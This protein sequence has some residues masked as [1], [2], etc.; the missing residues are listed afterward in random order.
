MLFVWLSLDK[1]C[2]H[3]QPTNKKVI[4]LYL[5]DVPYF[6]SGD[7]SALFISKNWVLELLGVLH[8]LQLLSA[9]MFLFAGFG[10]ISLLEM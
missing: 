9:N 1:I 7:I 3:R 4:Q 10:H 6:E 5:N 8:I 2:L